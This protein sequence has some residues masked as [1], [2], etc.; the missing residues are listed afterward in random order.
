VLNKYYLEIDYGVGNL[1]PRLVKGPAHPRPT[2]CALR[3]LSLH[4]CS[5]QLL[6]V[7]TTPFC[8]LFH[9]FRS[10]VWLLKALGFGFVSV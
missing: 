7:P 10:L 3:I 8:L 4:T 9:L 5:L 6:T 1:K 2:K